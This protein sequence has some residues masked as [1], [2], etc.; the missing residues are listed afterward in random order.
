[1]GITPSGPFIIPDMIAIAF[2]S[3]PNPHG[4]PNS[5]VIR[6]WMN[7][8][9]IA[10][11]N[12]NNWIIDFNNLA[13]L[14]EISL[15]EVPF[16]YIQDNVIAARTNYKTGG[17]DF[18]KFER[19]RPEMQ[20]AFSIIHRYIARSMVGKHHFFVWLSTEILPANLVIAFARSDDYFFGVLHSRIHEVWARAQ[21]TQ[22]R[23][24]ESGFRYTPT[25]CF[26]TF[27][28]PRPS[29]E[30]QMAIGLIAK[31]LDDL[32]NGWLNPPEWVYEEVL[33]FPGT[34]DGPWARYVHDPDEQGIG[35]VRYP[36]LVPRGDA[37]R[38]MLAKRT[39]TNLY[40]QRPTWLADMHQRLDA[41]AFAAY[42][43]DPS[44]PDDAL[45]AKLLERNLAM[46]SKE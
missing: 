8:A 6:P 36:R 46:K 37:F 2:L 9:A 32:R 25:T 35:T 10:N 26:E 28:L 44:M 20:S 30:Q 18:W 24:R 17:A 45:L 7:G 11:R 34:I 40:N 15:Y 42:G 5:S 31:E 21:G 12:L 4:K 43:W 13:S 22:L 39:L 1:M 38:E 3:S 33:E 27:P 19:S 16:Q 29:E 41:A 23:E 14:D